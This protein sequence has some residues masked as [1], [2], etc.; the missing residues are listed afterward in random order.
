M[1]VTA[2][3]L[4]F[5]GRIAGVGVKTQMITLENEILKVSFT[6]ISAQITSAIRKDNGYEYVHDGK[7]GWAQQN[8]ILFP[9][10]CSTFNGKQ[11]F[12]GKVYEMGKHGVVRH[13]NMDVV[14]ADENHVVFELSD[15]ED[16]L[17]QYPYHFCLRVTYTLQGDTI[18]IDYVI[19][20]RDGKTMPFQFGLH[21]AWH[22]PL[23]AGQSFSDYHLEFEQEEH[24]KSLIGD[25]D[26]DGTTIPLSYDIFKKAPTV[27]Y[28]GLKSKKVTL[29]DG[30]NGVSVNFEKFP[31]IA[32]WTPGESPFLCIEPWVGHGDLNEDPNQSMVEFASRDA[33]LSLKPGEAWGIDIDYRLF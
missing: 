10:V 29:S 32:F 7:V 31:W 16:R 23:K 3:I 11:L 12:D 8:P 9:M 25:C 17:K 19:S 15:N 18:H 6:P 24:A 30:T 2:T 5:S 26:L 22:C 4:I 27:L 28:T 1:K 14:E 21:P 33:T 13:A 20:N